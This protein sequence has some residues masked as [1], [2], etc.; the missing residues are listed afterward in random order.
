MNTV[1]TTEHRSHVNHLFCPPAQ[2]NAVDLRPLVGAVEKSH[3]L[4]VRIDFLPQRFR[5]FDQ[6]AIFQSLQAAGG[7]AE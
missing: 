6:S 7:Y 4:A 3:D 1:H 5:A 2:K